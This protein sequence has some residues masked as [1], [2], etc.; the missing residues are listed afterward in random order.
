MQPDIIQK[1]N[2]PVPRYTSYPP[3]N[4]FAA[5][6]ADDYLQAVDASNDAQ[7]NNISFYLHM[8]FCRHL[9]HYCGCNSY[10]LS[11]M[12]TMTDY[13]RALHREIDLLA[14]YRTSHRAA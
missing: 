3:A 10:P 2:K 5:F 14:L 7:Q 9:C 1:Y 4:F 6:T 13:V 8:P 12:D 11:N